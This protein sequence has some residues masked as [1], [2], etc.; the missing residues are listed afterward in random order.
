ML[1]ATHLSSFWT[2]S[3]SFSFSSS[4]E[5]LLHDPL[6]LVETAI[7]SHSNKNFLRSQRLEMGYCG[8]L[9]LF[10]EN[11][12]ETDLILLFYPKKTRSSRSHI[13]Y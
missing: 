9:W 13:Q 5:M 10:L 3:S 1:Q 8:S 7:Q 2:F 4:S 12:P 6:G 11:V